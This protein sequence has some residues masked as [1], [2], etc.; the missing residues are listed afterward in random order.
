MAGGIGVI[1]GALVEV[2]N[3]VDVGTNVGVRSV[4]DGGFVAVS[5]LRTGVFVRTS[6]NVAVDAGE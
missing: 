5:V 1:V 2:S 6:V 4:G 3:G